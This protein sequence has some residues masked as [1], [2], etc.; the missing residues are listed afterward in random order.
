MIYKYQGPYNYTSAIVT[1][2]ESSS[3]GVY[4]C[5]YKTAN[6]GL[7]VLY[8][9]KGTG[10]DGMRGR[11]LDHLR[12]DHWPDVTHFGIQLCDSAAEAEELE[13]KLIEYHKPKYN[14]LGK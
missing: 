4:L 12:E 13:G 11:L 14:T 8:I 9:G 3:I 10:E 7:K 5:G 2:W 6:N 1:A